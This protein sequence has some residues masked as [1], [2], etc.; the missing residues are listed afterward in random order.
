MKLINNY[1]K[2]ITDIPLSGNPE[3]SFFSKVFR[4]HTNFSII[5]NNMLGL[6]S[7]D[8]HNNINI[9]GDLIKS[10]DLEMNNIKINNSIPSNIGTSLLKDITLMTSNKKIEKLSGSYIEM[11]Y[12]LNNIGSLSTFYEKD[13][14]NIVCNTG[15][16]FHNLT[17]SGGCFNPNNINTTDKTANASTVISVCLPIPFSFFTNT[18]LSLP[19][20]LFHLNNPIKVVFNINEYL[21]NSATTPKYN[22][23]VNYILI[24]EEE[25][26]RFKSSKNEYI[27]QKVY[28]HTLQAVT[29]GINEYRIPKIYG[30]IKSMIWENTI[31]KNY[32]YNISINNILLCNTNKSYH[33]WTRHNIKKFNLKGGGRG[34]TSFT[35]YP[36][37]I[38]N[39]SIALYNFGLDDKKDDSPTGSVNSNKN[40]ISIIIEN[41]DN[42]NIDLDFILYIKTYNILKITDGKIELEYI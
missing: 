33:Y 32:K 36:I 25:Q 1:N 23:I 10:I 2:D 39:D 18:A 8:M 16:M 24:G 31:K 6:K 34:L 17:L 7:G 29:R 12:Q 5:R 37:V 14:A 41:N 13:D 3:I 11:Y 4:R 20:F 19:Y 21:L 30:N 9:N 28:E 22:F 27:I 42:T 15:N 35:G 40:Q 26:M 38:S